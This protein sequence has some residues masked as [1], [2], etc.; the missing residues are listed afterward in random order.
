MRYP[1]SLALAF[2]ASAAA[3]S[4]QTKL[5]RFPDIHDNRIV[6]TYGGDLWIVNAS[7][8]AAA[9][10]TAHPGVEVFAKF[11]P[12]GKWIAFTGQYDGDEQVY[13]IPSE[14]GEPRQLTFYPA[15]GPLAPR[16]GYDNQVYGW[17]NDG[18]YVIYRSL[19]DGWTLA[20]SRLYRVPVE[21]GPS[22]PLPMPVSGA[23][24]YSPGGNQLVYSPQARDFR[25]EKRYSGGQANE[26]YI[27][28]TE[29]HA[30]K[31]ITEGP[32]ASRDPMWIGKEI[33]FDSDRDGHFNLYAY[34]TGTGK[35]TQ[36][37]RN[38]TWD[39]RWPS[40][41]RE[42]RIVYELDGELNVLDVKTGKSAHIAI[43]VPDDGVNRRASY[44]SAANL[45]EQ[46]DLSPKGE[47]VLFAARGDIFSA[48]VEKG[49]TRNLTHSPGA[50]DKW[51]AW[52][53]DGSKIAFLSDASGEEE[54]YVV[55]QDGTSPPEKITSGGHA[56]RYQPQW[57]PD[58]QQI[59]F[60]D[61]DGRL[62]VASLVNHAAKEIA[63]STEGEIRDYDWSPGGGYLAFSIN[64][65][66]GF[67][68]L[69]VWSAKE[70]KLRRVTSGTFN[71]NSPAWDPGADYLY[72]L[73]DHEFQPQL[74]QIEF[75]FATNRSRGIFALALRKDVKNPFPVESDEVAIKK[76]EPAKESQS[77]DEKD[78]K[79]EQPKDK[80]IDF[81]GLEQRVTRVPLD[82]NNYFGLAV[83]SDALVYGVSAAPYYGRP[84][85]LKSTLRI[86]SFKDRKET[87]LADD[88]TGWRLSRD[89]SKALVHQAQAWNVYDAVPATAVP[90]PVSAK[91][92][93]STAGLMLEKVPAEEWKQIFNEVWRRYRDFFYAPNMHGYDWEALRLR[94]SELLP[95]V[96]HRSDLNYVIGEMIAE[97]TVQHAY[98]V[99]GDIELPPRPHA[100][101]PGARF[102]VDTNSGRYRIA[103]IFQGQNEEENY[104][105]PLT[106]VG[107]DAK[108]GDYVLAING[109]ELT[110]KQ[111]IYQLLRH[112]GDGP[113]QLTLN[114]T[115]T[116]TGARKVTYKPIA[117]ESDLLYLDWVT[118]NRKRV[119]E[120]SHG[121][122]AY[123][124]LPDM[125]EAGIREFIKWYYPQLRKEALLI[126]D[127]ANGGGNVSRMVI[128]R[129]T[130]K[131]MGLDYSRTIATPQVYP[132]SVFIGPKAVLL[133]GNSASDG[134]IFPWMFHTAGLGPLI[135]ERSWGGVVGITDHG[136]LMD[137]GTVNVPEFAYAKADGE[138]AVEGH[139]VD[140]DIVVVN[141]PKSV[142]EGH[143]PQ[144]ERGVAELLRAL[145]KSNPKL[146]EHAPYPVKL[147]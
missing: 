14:G 82:A 13:I 91:K 81:D 38:T 90:A 39:V 123:M 42:H 73:A 40:T 44:I 20:I 120:L 143:D 125:G 75:D 134:D 71:E 63:H 15:R 61:K 144:L 132:D 127:R 35:T 23:A 31:R 83:K 18:R 95:D 101:L 86:F 105:S 130:R 47:R 85:A 45:I 46:A 103:K 72:F 6:F 49:P 4:A 106:E 58:N 22:E 147:K 93:V 99:G 122:I 97:L 10:L 5:L 36:V 57:S 51:P 54:I 136:P 107:V 84:A 52:S 133:D 34:D 87:T 50:H 56:F 131:L 115:P 29:P 126:D 68:A 140:P 119:D 17:T 138:W 24:S 108:T 92:T 16:W 8:G 1:F 33:Y 117:S 78:K 94:Y 80:G 137:G 21:G 111:D 32:R 139:G 146:P 62:W 114:A 124:H 2:L 3:L 12:D 128:G 60:S 112:A 64:D 25:T 135:G 77:K 26:L 65:P 100:G 28:D 96:A 118:Q 59:A 48:P 43:R 116:L 37:T 53:P 67:S 41:D 55:A 88:I 7:G 69:Y 104:R 98:I 74:S 141:D 142:I 89:G 110:A 70:D 109:E 11:S 27:F 102:E 9:R 79:P 30:A 129:L 19:R 66:S 76:D 113:V 145:E 121:R